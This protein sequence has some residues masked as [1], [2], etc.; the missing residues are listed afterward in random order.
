MPCSTLHIV[1]LVLTGVCHAVH[2]TLFIWYLLEYAMQYTAHC[3]S[4]T[5]WSMPC[6]TLHI[7]Y[8]VLSGVCHAVHC[9]LF[10][11]YYWSMP[12]SILHIVYLA[13]TGVCH[14]V[15][16][17]LFIKCLL[18]YAIQ[19]TAHCLSGAKRSMPCS[20]LYIVYLVLTG[21]C[22]AVHCTLFIRHPTASFFNARH[23][24]VFW[25]HVGLFCTLFDRSFWDLLFICNWFEHFF[26]VSF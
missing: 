14:A 16:C 20:I 17:T 25:V 19:Y 6:S 24:A 21:V 18:Q 1:Y 9:T 8:L 10:I 13:L 7:V 26:P 15:H 3:L 5:Y 12:C 11:W 22:H 2:C 23:A 4:G